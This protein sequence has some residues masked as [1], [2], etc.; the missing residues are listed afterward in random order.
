[1]LFPAYIRKNKDGT[2]KATFPDFDDSFSGIRNR[3]YLSKTFKHA[4]EAALRMR[5]LPPCEPS[6]PQDW[7]GDRR[8][9]GG[10]WTLIDLN[11][12]YAGPCPRMSIVR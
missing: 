1:M 10:Y 12:G 9:Q 2:H 11:L 6:R 4:V 5:K 7:F 8:F 3:N